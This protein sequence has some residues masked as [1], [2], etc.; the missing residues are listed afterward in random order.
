ME[1]ETK[2]ET[3]PKKWTVEW[4]MRKYGVV[5]TKKEPSDYDTYSLG[6]KTIYYSTSHKCWKSANLVRFDSEKYAV[7]WLVAGQTRIDKRKK[8]WVL[9]MKGVVKQEAFYPRP[10]VKYTVI[11]LSN[12]G[13]KYK[14]YKLTEA[15]DEAE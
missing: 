11:G 13:Y 6:Y 14:R 15:N 5:Q 4:A 2:V 10:N 7:K 1:S 3:K 9:D 8:K 12:G